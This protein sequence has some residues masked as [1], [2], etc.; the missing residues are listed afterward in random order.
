MNRRS[1]KRN[2]NELARTMDGVKERSFVRGL[3]LEVGE[4][5]RALVIC[6]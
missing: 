5:E 4:V 3:E 1:E 6:G 2:E